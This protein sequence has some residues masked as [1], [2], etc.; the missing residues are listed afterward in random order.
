MRFKCRI[1]GKR[2]FARVTESL[3]Y[4]TADEVRLFK[5]TQQYSASNELA[6]FSKFCYSI[7]GCDGK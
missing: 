5:I 3:S 4:A 1:A 6:K 7:G 2:V